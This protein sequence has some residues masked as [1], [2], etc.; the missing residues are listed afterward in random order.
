MKKQMLISLLLSAVLLMNSFSLPAAALSP[1]LLQTVGATEPAS[2]PETTGTDPGQENVSSKLPFG[3]VSIQEG[4]RTIEGMKP[5]AGSERRLSTSQGVFAYEANTGTVVYSYNADV[6]LSPG[7]LAKVVMAL[8]A[9][10]N[11]ELDEVVTCVPGI[12]SKIP[13]GSS[14]V[15]L[16][17][18]EELTVEDLLHCVMLQYANDAAVALAEHVAGTTNAYVE[19][20]N[21]RVK[22]MGCMN[23]Q[24]GNISGLDTAVSYST[25]RDMARIFAEACENETFVRISG[26]VE[27]TVPATNLEKERTLKTA[28]YMID[29]SVIP[30]FLDNYVKAGM[31]SHTD[32]SGSSMVSMSEYNGMKL[33]CVVLGAMRT[34]NAEQ[35]WRVENYGNYEEM[36][37]LMEFLYSGFKVN[38]VLYDGQALSQFSVIG[39]ES[40]VV[41]E[42]RANYATVLPVDCSM[43]NLYM[44]Y[45]PVRGDYIAPIKKGE[46]IATVA[47]KYRN[48][49][50]AETELF[51]MN[52]VVKA[53]D[54][55]VTVRSTAVKT[56]ND[57]EG[58]LGF[59]GSVGVLIVG[60]F[61]LYLLYNTYRRAKRRAQH[62]RRR[63]SRRRSY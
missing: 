6:K 25:A 4:C 7:T 20:M 55:E 37:S 18:E 38:Q 56:E 54:S 61:G 26:T 41:G 28:N 58:I 8:V 2:V 53:E 39:G 19:L 33:V 62:R 10:E 60:V 15:K 47:I 32:G 3:Q 42:V 13:A 24:F 45:T 11:C 57:M 44:E 49:Y 14:S 22:K 43:D 34:Y 51:A 9:I 17:S 16:K 21:Q 30:Q 63:A 48:S 1:D 52:P 35:T 40:D 50:I 46:M 23:T 12:Q 5:L 31:T 59:V 29:N 27:Y 36:Q